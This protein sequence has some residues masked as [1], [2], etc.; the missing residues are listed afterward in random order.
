MGEDVKGARGER[1]KRGEKK[2]RIDEYVLTLHA[3]HPEAC[4]GINTYSS[5]LSFFSLRFTPSPP[6]PLHILIPQGLPLPSPK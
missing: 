2:E 6:R 3:P 5:I 4:G 1:V